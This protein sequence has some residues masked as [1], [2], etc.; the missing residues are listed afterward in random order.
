MKDLND[1]LR[2][3]VGVGCL[4]IG[5]LIGHYSTTPNVYP[6]AVVC[7]FNENKCT[8]TWINTVYVTN[9]YDGWDKK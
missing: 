3:I 7:E 6:N 2:V 8:E 1:Q 5:F 9:Q 4:A